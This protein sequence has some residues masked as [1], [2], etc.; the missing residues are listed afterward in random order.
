MPGSRDEEFASYV[1]ARSG[2][3]LRL[4]VGLTGTRPAGEDLLQSA[5]TKV[6]LSW[7]KVSAAGATDA[8]VRR[9]VVNTHLSLLRRRRVREDLQ[10]DLVDIAA[11][12]PSYGIEDRDALWAALAKLGRRQRAIV[13]LRYYEDLPDDQIAEL[14]GCS[15]STVR[16]QAMRALNT[17]KDLPEL[18]GHTPRPGACTATW[19]TP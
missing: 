4:A 16:S 6:Y 17:L 14:I 8:Y 18:A 15:P 11:A 2:P 10:A 3:L 9:I 13:L 5:L 7:S 12:A 1:S 19:E